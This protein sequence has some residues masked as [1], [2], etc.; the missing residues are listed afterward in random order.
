MSTSRSDSYMQ[1]VNCAREQN[2]GM[3]DLQAI[4]PLSRY[5]LSEKYCQL[6][7]S[8]RGLTCSALYCLTL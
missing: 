8:S 6:L 3:T 7:Q 2:I 4:L 1:R 5:E